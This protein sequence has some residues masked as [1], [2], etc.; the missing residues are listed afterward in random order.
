[1][2]RYILGVML[3]TIPWAAIHAQ[4][5]KELLADIDK[6][7]QS[8]Q[9]VLK[10]SDIRIEL[11][12]GNSKFDPEDNFN[13][14]KKSLAQQATQEQLSRFFS[15]L[16]LDNKLLYPYNI[17]SIDK[18]EYDL[19]ELLG[20]KSSYYMNNSDQEPVYTPIRFQFLDG[21]VT[22]D[23]TLVM[24]RNT[25]AARHRKQ[26]QENGET[27][28]YVSE[29]KMSELEKMIWKSSSFK[30]TI[31]LLSP[32]PLKSV[33]YRIAL[34][35]ASKKQYSF[36]P[37]QKVAGTPY[38]FITL[39]TIA[40]TK[41]F[42]T[43]PDTETDGAVQIE[44][45][46]KDGRVLSQKS[47]SSNTVVSD[48]KKAMYL[49]WIETLKT[50]RKQVD[51]GTIKTSQEL[52][53][54][55]KAHP[56]AKADGDLKNYKSAVYTFAGPVDKVS[57]IVSDSLPEKLSFD[58]TYDLHY[59][60][61]EQDVFIAVDFE[62]GHT[63]LID[64]Q[65]KWVVQPQFNEYFRPQ[66]QYFY[67]DQI[68]DEEN[69]YRFDPKTKALQKVGYRVD[70]PEVYDGKYVK[71]EPR[72]NGPIGVVDA[73]SG[74]IVLPM[75]HDFVHF[76]ENK[77]WYVERNDKEG[78]YD[79]N[80]KELLPPLYDDVDI[81]GDY[82][83]VKK[84][85]DRKNAYN[86]SGRNI[87]QDKFSEIKGTFSDGLLL[88][89][90]WKTERPG[91]REGSRYYYIDSLNHIKIDVNAKGYQSPEPFSGGMAI[92][93]DKNSS[94]GYINTRG[95]LAIP[96]RFR[97]AHDFYPTSQLALVQLDDYSEVLIDKRGK[98]VR[99]IE[100]EVYRRENSAAD[101]ASRLYVKGGKVYNEYG[102]EVTD[103]R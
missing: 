62:K 75:E 56:V 11:S 52:K 29:E 20:Y 71:I 87:T 41:V 3:M 97:Y 42:C 34:P 30:E 4:T 101:R 50:A 46:Y 47:Y 35:L 83:F 28:E 32:K 40:G 19:L 15:K 95:E 72:V 43:L 69:T 25:I 99:K 55:L 58:M 48:S 24:S 39:D 86:Q 82:F 89:V 79:R 9:V 57:F 21:S 74:K 60:K 76:K 37:G 31:A 80:F 23:T 63:G 81:D 44:A 98:V 27:Y 59:N 38:G 68:N 103:G 7:L 1:M 92:V 13:F 78:V 61:A 10:L 94:K 77:F 36:G 84:N 90:N 51:K 12:A 73:T 54:Y 2:R 93:E 66:N 102:E 49:Q 45:Y 5:Q 14:E 16:D 33:T 8:L 91:Y 26:E 85:G 67:W 64:K 88:V 96:C 100:G 17:V 65:G 22:T 70:D 18:D 53:D 6:D